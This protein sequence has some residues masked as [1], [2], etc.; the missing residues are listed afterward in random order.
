MSIKLESRT[1]RT[2]ESGAYLPGSIKNLTSKDDIILS[3]ILYNRS[4]LF[5]VCDVSSDTV[6]GSTV[7]GASVGGVPDG[8]ILPDNVTINFTITQE[9]CIVILLDLVSLNFLECHQPP[10]CILGLLCR[11]SVL[12]IDSM[13]YFAVLY[14]GGRGD[15]TVAGCTTYV[16]NISYVSCVCNHLTSFACLVVSEL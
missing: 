6:I 2:Q 7:I 3:F 16:V 8:T 14:K 13:I 12:G 1:N 4:T 11:R 15:W 9:V 10:L 5:P